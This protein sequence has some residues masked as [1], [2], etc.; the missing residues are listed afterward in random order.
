[1]PL[2]GLLAGIVAQ[3]PVVG[4]ANA[5]LGKLFR[6]PNLEPPV[7]LAK[8]VLHLAHGTAK[9]QRFEQAFFHQGRTAGRLHHGGGHVAAGDD[10]VLRAGA[11]VH[12]VGLVEEVAV[13]LGGLRVLH[14]HVAGLAD[15][16][17]QLVDGLRGVHHRM[18]RTRA[19]LAHGVEAAV[20]RVEGRVR[21]P[22]LVKVQVVHV[23]VEH[24]LDGLGVVEHA[25][26]G[27]LREREHARLDLF[28]IHALEQRVGLDL[29]LDGSGLELALRDRADDAEV[30]A[31]G[32]HEHGDR[33]GHD[34]AVQDGL[35]AVA[36]HHHHVARRH[37]VVPDHLVAGAGAVGHEEAVVGVEDARR[38]ALAG[39]NGAVVVQQLPQLFHRVAHVG[40]QHV[41]AEELVEH[42]AHR[43]LEEG[44]TSRVARTV[45]GVRAVFRVVQ[46]GLLLLLSGRFE[47]QG[48]RQIPKEI[49]REGL[50]GRYASDLV[51]D[52]LVIRRRR[53]QLSGG[54]LLQRLS[55]NFKRTF[56]DHAQFSL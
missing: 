24:A 54:E 8:V 31:R 32:L 43:R 39:T 22:G 14:Q 9:V 30:V 36:V 46:Q 20:E 4:A 5:F 44:N 3:D 40:A 55:G 34:D 18:L 35:V 51:V 6:A 25:V 26:V 47:W 28:R 38:V 12:Q 7:V 42:L 41:L 33:P 11:G 56:F 50:Y 49:R 21:Q 48:L 17:Q 37:R 27:G 15:A 10:A 19:L 1:M 52:R 13:Q 53:Y 23:A 16:G 29:G 45:P 2:A